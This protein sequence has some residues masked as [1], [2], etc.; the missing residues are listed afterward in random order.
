MLTYIFLI[1]GTWITP[2]KKFNFKTLFIVVSVAL[3]ALHLTIIAMDPML[4]LVCQFQNIFYNS[5]SSSY[6]SS[7]CHH[8][9]GPNATFSLLLFLVLYTKLYKILTSRCSYF[10]Q[11]NSCVLHYVLKKNM[12]F[13]L[14]N[15]N[16]MFWWFN[17]LFL[18]FIL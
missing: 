1:T 9:H 5:F 11:H 7:L 16:H 6:S 2:V 8:C 10:E 13:I 3:L 17:G 18:T 12:P 4:L 15:F 14:V